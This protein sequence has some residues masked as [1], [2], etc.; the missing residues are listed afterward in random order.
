[1][2]ENKRFVCHSCKFSSAYH[3][4][5]TK[6]NF[7]KNIILMEDSYL[8]KDPFSTE[9]GFIT[10]GSHCSMCQLSVCCSMECSLFYT[11]RF[12]ID[13]VKSKIGKFPQEIQ[14]E[15]SRKT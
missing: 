12:C 8:C 5:G 1:M 4:Y 9:G 6:P 13:C 15:I 7:A 2:E 10:L 3:Y 11:K 14:Q